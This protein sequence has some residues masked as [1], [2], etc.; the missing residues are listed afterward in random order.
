MLIQF[1]TSGALQC[2]ADFILTKGGFLVI[3]G[4][5]SQVAVNLVSRTKK[6]QTTTSKCSQPYP[7]TVNRVMPPIS[8]IAFIMTTVHSPCDFRRRFPLRR[9]L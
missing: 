1:V 7:K 2:V 5:E 6:H 8:N 4:T 3:S 9:G